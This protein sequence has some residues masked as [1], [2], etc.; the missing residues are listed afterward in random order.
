MHLDP[1]SLFLTLIA[2]TVVLG[3]L[4]LWVWWINRPVPVLKA[5][6]AAYLLAAFALVLA[7]G[8][9]RWP[10]VLTTDLAGS[11]ALG[12]YMLM[13]GSLRAFNRRSVPL[14]L[15]VLAV[16]MWLAVCVLVGAHAANPIRFELFS[17]QCGIVALLI[18][19]EFLHCSGGAAARISAFLLTCS[20]GVFLLVRALMLAIDAAP[21]L[22]WQRQWFLLSSV[23]TM[24]YVVVSAF[25]LLSLVMAQ[26]AHAHRLSS[27]QDYLTG[28]ANRRGFEVGSVQV[29]RH[30]RQRR[31]PSAVI[32]F[33]LDRF[34]QINDTL[35]HDAG[36]RVLKL[37]GSVALDAL[38]KTDLLCRLGGDEFLALLP[39]TT[40]EQ[41]KEIG[42]RIAVRFI[43][44]CRSL[45][46]MGP[47]AS[48]V[49]LGIAVDPFS[50]GNLNTVIEE[51]DRGLYRQKQVRRAMAAAG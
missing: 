21:A 44:M 28:A 50:D 32:L 45:E 7:G 33:D 31:Q 26:L 4:M 34:K 43:E 27:E 39:N 11:T 24:L 37:F 10:D 18:G 15:G 22:T 17:A 49:S 19:F 14:G 23:E 9:D 36:D 20:H 13:S 47:L 40:E 5:W 8:R 29:L 30:A 51:A 25:L 42:Q 48:G 38:R 2:F 6:G 46:G 12:A 3:L 41:A 16:A 1:G 35:G